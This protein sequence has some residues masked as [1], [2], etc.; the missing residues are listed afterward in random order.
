MATVSEV[1]GVGEGGQAESIKNVVS[2]LNKY[3]DIKYSINGSAAICTLG[4][5]SKF[6][7]SNHKLS[8]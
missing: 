7:P 8:T 3:Y 1:G 2:I 6:S 4:E 5:T